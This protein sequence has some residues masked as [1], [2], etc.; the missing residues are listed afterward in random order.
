MRPLYSVGTSIPIGRIVREHRAALLP[1]AVV[2]AINAAVLGAVVLPLSRR[3][4]ANEIRA[5]AAERAQAAAAAE[6]KAAESVRDGKTRASTDLDTFY[7]QVLPADV[8]AARRM[9]HVKFQQKA[10]EHDVQYQ[11][12]STSEEQLRGSTLNR[13]TVSMTLTGD[14]DD[15]RALIYELEAS[16]DFFVIDNVKLTE[17]SDQSAPLA[18]D[19][20]VSTYFRMARPESNGR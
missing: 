8:A 17:G 5:A 2:L 6:F 18:V 4:A 13:L 1:L 10:R 9:T 16:P 3:V 20:D 11:R 14:Y 19:L 7:T 15:I 12:G